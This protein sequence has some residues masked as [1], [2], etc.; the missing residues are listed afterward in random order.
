MS[1][2]Q[3]GSPSALVQLVRT[4]IL[5]IRLFFDGRVPAWTK[6]IP[7]AALAYII[8]PLDFLP[9]LVPG[10]G[11]LDDLTVL[12][13]A[14]WAFVQLCPLKIVRDYTGESKVVDGEFR[15]VDDDQAQRP[16]ANDQIPPSGER[17]S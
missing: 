4:L 7:L 16:S 15:I 11:Q 17:R 3:P 14:L 5:A 2:L 6:I 13:I 1:R 10:F 12:L 8:F 9:D